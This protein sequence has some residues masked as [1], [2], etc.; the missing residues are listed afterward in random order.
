MIE[1]S[2]SDAFEFLIQENDR[3][4]FK[5]MIGV[6]PPSIVPSKF[7]SLEACGFV[8]EVS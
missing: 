1:D 8:H 4:S 3:S 5:K 6:L 2:L 7:L